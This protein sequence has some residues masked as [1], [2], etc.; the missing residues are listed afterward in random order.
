MNM[1]LDESIVNVSN[2]INIEESIKIIK[3]KTIKIKVPELVKEH[4]ITSIYIHQRLLCLETENAYYYYKISPYSYTE[5][6]FTRL[7]KYS[8]M[9]DYSQMYLVIKLKSDGI[10]LYDANS[11]FVRTESVDPMGHIERFMI[12]KSKNKERLA[13][14]FHLK[15]HKINHDKFKDDFE[16]RIGELT[17]EEWEKYHCRSIDL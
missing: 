8:W 11:N 4:V 13:L 16:Y 9:N 10:D 7:L 1:I 17:Y 6:S 15:N 5:M 14:Y 3:I 12:D 2:H